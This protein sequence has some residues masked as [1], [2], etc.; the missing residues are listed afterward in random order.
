MSVSQRKCPR[1]DHENVPRA[2]YCFQCGQNLDQ[3][4]TMERPLKK[5]L[6]A[7]LDGEP[8]ICLRCGTLNL[9]DAR[10]CGHCGVPFIVPDTDFNLV[11]LGSARTS[12]GQ[13]RTNNEDNVALWA[14]DGVL[15]ALVADGLG[16]EAAGEQASRLAVEAVQADFLGEEREAELLHTLS[17]DDLSQRM[18]NAIRA[19][20]R[21]VFE[22][23]R[24]DLHLKGMGTTSTLAL[25]RGNRALIAHVGDSR[26]YLIDGHE[27]SI[28][29]VTN[30][31]SFTQALVASGHITAEQ[32]TG[33]PMSN[34]LYRAL[35]QQPE[36]EVDIFSR[37][38]KS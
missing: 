34:V 23:S 15:L 28:H 13:V 25:V 38:V 22:R 24:S 27:G 37:Y 31:H 6:P 29:Q 19:A 11:A 7:G 9:H 20:N 4:P 1:C 18:T 21:A 3:A 14:I 2:I 8:L 35:G 16:G 5:P 32:A 12:V 30:D 17:E 10:Y 26:A 36:V 33:H